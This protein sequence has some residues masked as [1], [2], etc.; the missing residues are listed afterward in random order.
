MPDPDRQASARWNRHEFATTHWSLVLRAGRDRSA[1]SLE[2]L[3]QLCRA[4]WFPLYAFARRLGCASHEAQDLTQEFF[5]RLLSKDH[6]QMADPSRGKFRSFLLA[7]FKHMIANER[8]DATRQKRGGGARLFSLDEQEAEERYQLE[9]A[10]LQ[11]PERLFEKRWA[12]TTLS[13]V[14]DRL[15]A[16]YSGHTFRFDDLKVFL[17]EARGSAAFADVAL[18]LGVTEAALKSLVHRMRRRYAELFRDE[19]AQTVEKPEDVEEEI[20]YMLAVLSN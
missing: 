2:A 17:I 7:S 3:E 13:R 10:D 1:V 9:H 4:Y 5:S 20:G 15:A 14:L 8:R 12:E 11:T 6:L 16:E 19:V 18:R